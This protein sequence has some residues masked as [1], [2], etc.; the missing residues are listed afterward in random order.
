M[1]K[2]GLMAFSHQLR[3]HGFG[4]AILAV[5]AEAIVI[6]FLGV[7]G[8][9]GSLLRVSMLL[10]LGRSAVLLHRR[11]RL[12]TP[13]HQSRRELLWQVVFAIGI[14]AAISATYWFVPI[15]RIQLPDEIAARWRWLDFVPSLFAVLF[16]PSP[17]Q[18]H[19]SFFRPDATDCFPGPL[20]WESLIY[21][22]NAIVAYAVL[23]VSMIH[24]ARW[25]HA[26]GSD[27]VHSS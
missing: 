24:L 20:W 18:S 27:T 15:S 5:I 25:V 11:F 23:I 12:R 1:L 26:Q 9:A 14:G 8:V 19:Y 21:L 6:A 22:R 7:P 16:V 13:S 10:L 4:V 3:R 17:M 2:Y